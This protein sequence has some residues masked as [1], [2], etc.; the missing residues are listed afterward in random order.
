[1]NLKDIMLSEISPQKEKHFY[2]NLW[3]PLYEEIKVKLLVT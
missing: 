1:M 2:L 3:F